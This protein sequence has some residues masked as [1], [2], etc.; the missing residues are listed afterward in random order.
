MSEI[1]TTFDD[2]ILRPQ[3]GLGV[4]T[5][6]SATQARVNF[7][8][9]GEPT[10]SL[11][12][13]Q[14]YGLGEVGEL[15]LIEGQVDLVLARIV[16]VV[17][18]EAERRSLRLGA[19]SDERLDA[20]GFAQFLGT[21]RADTLR[22][23]AGVTTYPRLG[24]RVYSAPHAFIS[25]IPRLME[26]GMV[27][28]S[29]PTLMIGHVSGHG[30]AAVHIRPEKL[31]G[32]HC[33]ILGAT[34][35]GKS[36]TVARLV[37]ECA[38][39]HSKLVVLDATGEYRTLRGDAIRHHHLGTP[40]AAAAGSVECS[41]PSADLQESDFVALFEPSGKAQGPK[42]R[43]AIRSLRLVHLEPNLGQ[44]GLLRKAHADKA[45]IEARLKVNSGAIEAPNAE[46]NPLRLAYQL[47]EECVFLEGRLK[48]GTPDTSRW[49]GYSEADKSYC[50]SLAARVHAIVHSRAFA[51]VFKAN[52]EAFGASLSAFLSDDRARVMR[53]CLGGVSYEH[54][55]REFLVNV[56]GRGLL[57]EARLN[58]FRAMPLLV[59]LDE[60][61]NFLGGTSGHEDHAIKLDAFE[62]IAREG[63]KYGL[64]IC[65]AT[66]RPRDLTEG[67]LSQIGTLVVHRLTNDR[68]REVVERA[69]GEVDRTASAFLANLQQGEAAVIGVDFPIPL[70]VR[71]ARP[72]EPPA[73]DGP[74][75][76]K[77]W[78][79]NR[80]G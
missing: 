54:R 30:G 48:N 53:V 70:T 22:V 4:V 16:D 65:L 26:R 72:A 64:N 75:Y 78:S 55:A 40:V 12:E 51:P 14:R 74:D 19:G 32:R 13:A 73:S 39:Y 59:F 50:L 47:M 28:D 2:G 15:V 1:A 8:A 79:P 5:A 7:A 45:H 35:G 52:A 37:E 49:G 42:L 44:D 24:D 34:G 10:G 11:F 76:Q 46:F 66:Q 58:R 17:V 41:L 43:E 21:V 20:F 68:D 71:I 63:R 36:W 38:R 57:R 23:S 33:A 3:L 25:Q 56:I 31:F 18:P 77:A 80:S 27:A 29:G 9:A 61:H 60:A 6:V 67:V 69:C 62:L